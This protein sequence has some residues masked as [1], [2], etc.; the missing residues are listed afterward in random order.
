MLCARRASGRLRSFAKNAQDDA[1]GLPLRS[2]LACLSNRAKGEVERARKASLH[3]DNCA[4]LG[5][6]LLNGLGFVLGNA[7]LDVLGRSIHQFLGFLQA[8]AG[9]LADGLDYIDL[10][11]ADFLEDDG[12]LRLLLGRSRRRCR[13]RRPPP[14]PGPRL[15]PRRPGALPVSS[16]VAA[17]SSSD[18]PT[19][20]SS[21]CCRSAML[22]SP[23]FEL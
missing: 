7:F 9:D 23:L 14:S 13:P 17:A 19:I 21:N 20:E 10:I 18:N 12:K 8:Q 1:S 11:G 22:V 4:S 16:P 2:F 3:F 6:L 15:P 5:K